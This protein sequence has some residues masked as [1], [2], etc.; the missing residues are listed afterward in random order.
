MKRAHAELLSARYWASPLFTRLRAAAV[1]ASSTDRGVQPRTVP[2]GVG[3][4]VLGE[5]TIFGAMAVT[6]G[7]VGPRNDDALDAGVAASLWW[8]ERQAIHRFG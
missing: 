1:R 4:V 3:P 6:D 5:L 2:V 8:R 7:D